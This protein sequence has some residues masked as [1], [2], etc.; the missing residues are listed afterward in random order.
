[1]TNR[2]RTRATGFADIRGQG[3]AIQQQ[4]HS[5]SLRLPADVQQELREREQR[6][7]Q[8]ALPAPQGGVAAM[9]LTQHCHRPWRH[10]GSDD[11]RFATPPSCFPRPCCAAVPVRKRLALELPPVAVSVVFRGGAAPAVD[12]EPDHLPANAAWQYG[13][14][15]DSL[16]T[17]LSCKRD[18]RRVGRRQLEAATDWSVESTKACAKPFAGSGK[19]DHIQARPRQC[20]F[21]VRTSNSGCQG[22]VE[23]DHSSPCR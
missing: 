2:H 14:T 6:A 15:W 3:R 10:P 16:A 8:S 23:A 22:P 5:P 11:H 19:A 21:C 12:L 1:M 18:E 13:S 7:L 4:G 17:P 20:R 9:A